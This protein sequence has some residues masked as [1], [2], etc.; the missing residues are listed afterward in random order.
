M[1]AKK[2]FIG[3]LVLVILSA[4]VYIMLPGKVRLDV[5]PTNTKFSIFDNG[6]FVLAATEYVYLYDGSTKIQALDREI[7]YFNES[8]IIK[9]TRKTS[10]RNNI[11]IFET[12][13]FDSMVTDIEQIPVAHE[14]DC[15][16]CAGKILQF[17]YRGIS[18]DGATMD[19]VTPFTFGQ[20]KLSW[21]PGSYYAKV[22][23]QKSPKIVIK[24]KP[25]QNYESFN[26]RLF[27]PVFLNKELVS[28]VCIPV[29]R[30]WTE[31]I[32]HYKKCKSCFNTTVISANG[33]F[34]NLTDGKEYDI[35]ETCRDYDCIDYKEKKEHV[36]E[37]VGCTRLGQVNVAGK[38]ISFDNY[39]CEYAGNEIVCIAEKEGG[40]WNTCKPDGSVTCF[41]IN[42]NTGKERYY[43]SPGINVGKVISIESN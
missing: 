13:V 40:Q 6:K 11:S 27:D 3:F 37:Q 16:N 31:Q 18:Y 7:A 17:E 1:A 36:K 24:Y 25:T 35:K 28:N 22:I 30:T 15:I 19:I 29:Y 2:Y 43:N 42:L 32:P 41:K 14:T 12:Y 34:T 10:Y 5:A 38:V 39:W 8:G 26:V 9:I 23:Q 20:M 4:S 21:Q 33:K